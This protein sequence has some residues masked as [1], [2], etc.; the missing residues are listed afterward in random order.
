MIELWGMATTITRLT[1]EW[2]GGLSVAKEKSQFLYLNNCNKST[3]KLY[4]YM[5]S[6]L[7]GE[8]VEVCLLL[9]VLCNP[10][11]RL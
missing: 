5:E 3:Q 11:E 4:S 6:V 7:Y 1:S 2:V 8:C 10:I 9:F